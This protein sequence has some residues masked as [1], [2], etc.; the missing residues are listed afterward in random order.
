MSEVSF[1]VE[2]VTALE[3]EIKAAEAAGSDVFRFKGHEFFVPYAKYV[4]E[5][6]KGR[7]GDAQKT[8]TAG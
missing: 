3:Q 7:F 5:Y 1:E 4:V 6:L 8:T 2:D